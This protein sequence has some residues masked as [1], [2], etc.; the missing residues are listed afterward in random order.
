[1]VWW[2]ASRVH[3]EGRGL[4][5]EK[6]PLLGFRSTPS[7]AGDAEVLLGVSALIVGRF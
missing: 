7:Q 6:D 3:T 5:P 2:Y 1:M 4:L